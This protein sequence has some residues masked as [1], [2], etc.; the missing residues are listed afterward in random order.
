MPDV[1]PAPPP[2]ATAQPNGAAPK[3]APAAKPEAGNTLPPSGRIPGKQVKPTTAAK[4]PPP[5][6]AEGEAPAEG[7][8]PPAPEEDDSFEVVEDG[9]KR[10]YTREQA[11]R[12]L[13]KRGS[14][15]KRY[16]EV[17]EQTRQVQAVIEALKDPERFES[18]AQ[19][20]GHDMDAIAM[21]R[22]QA[23]VEHEALTP[24][25]Q[26]LV[27]LKRKTAEYE[28]QETK[29]KEAAE[30]RSR[31][32]ADQ[33]TFGRL[34]KGFLE[35]ANRNGLEGTPDNLVRM[36]EVAKEM[37]DLGVPLTE[38]Q[39]IA[40]VKEREEATFSQLESKVLKSLKGEAL[41][42]RLGPAVVEEVLRWSVE[43]IRGQA[44]AAKP[45]TAAEPRRPSG[46]AYMTDGEFR[47]K[48]GF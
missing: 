19:E 39:L 40:E 29:R 33:A 15:T 20:L 10:R 2:T 43:R 48:Y 12:E 30:T 18:I 22:L 41:A 37:L 31:E 34:E 14:S 21:R 5:P 6:A 24:E 23:R 13:Q 38:D 9:V 25:Q 32:A 3:P 11:I 42:K 46:P 28:A 26:E 44:P 7:T 35:A 27:A 4:A 17:K 36:V 16:Q 1:T 45:K 8:A 47:K